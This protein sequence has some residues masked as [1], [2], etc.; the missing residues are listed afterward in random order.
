MTQLPHTRSCFVCGD[1]NPLGLNLR[2]ETDGTMVHCRFVPR[3][4]H[5]GFKETLHGGITATILDEVMVWV[6]GVRT[7]SFAYCAE[8]SIRYALP[9]KPGT[10]LI[11]TARLTQNRRQKLFETESE[12]RTETGALIASATGKYLPIPGKLAFAALADF[13]GG[14]P[15]FEWMMGV[16]PVPADLKSEVPNL[17]SPGSDAS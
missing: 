15:G 7:K 5:A 12:M 1:H 14:D 2:F 9:G 8:M 17:K 6:V 16:S 13:T 3:P 4:E 10:P 11:A